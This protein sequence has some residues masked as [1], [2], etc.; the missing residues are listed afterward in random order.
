VLSIAYIVILSMFALDVF[1]E[2]HGFLRIL[3]ALAIHLIPPLVLIGGLVLAWRWEW[4]GAALYAAVG[5]LYVVSVLQRPFPLETRI[6]SAFMIAVPAF[7]VA[8]LFLVNW[9]KHAE[10]IRHEE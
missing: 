3:L 6:A 9:L 2:K 4:I 8:A 10:Q 5:V 1:G 7:L